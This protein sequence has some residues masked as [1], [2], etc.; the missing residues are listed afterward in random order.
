L[1]AAEENW[2]QALREFK[3]ALSSRPSPE[4]HYVLGSLY[5][6]LG[7]DS[8]ALRH[9]RKAIE[10]DQNY[11]EAFYLVGLI[12]RRAGH[13]D[14]ARVAFESATA[15][16]ILK[17]PRRGLPPDDASAAPLFGLY[18]SRSKKLLTGGDPRL[19]KALRE[20]ALK[21]FAP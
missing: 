6:K 21:A 2:P 13:E 5:F 19:A 15:R 7:R 14:L 4:A 12:H 10:M 20:E 11:G 18:N 1:F 17:P 8:L 9:L 3:R 16:H